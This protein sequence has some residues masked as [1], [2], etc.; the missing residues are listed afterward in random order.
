[1]ADTK[2][3]VENNG[4]KFVSMAVEIGLGNNS[5]FTKIAGALGS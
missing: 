2:K 4:F 3:L 5:I 1:M